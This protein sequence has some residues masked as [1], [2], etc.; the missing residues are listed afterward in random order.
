[1]SQMSGRLVEVTD[2]K[3]KVRESSRVGLRDE[4]FCGRILIR[5]AKK[6]GL[7]QGGN[8]KGQIRQPPGGDGVVK[9]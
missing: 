9:K 7:T 3:G 2:F 4:I 8:H 6:Q 1:M 5:L